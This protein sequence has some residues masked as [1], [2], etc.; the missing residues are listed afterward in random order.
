MLP[1]NKTNSSR[2]FCINPEK[3][4]A[5]ANVGGKSGKYKAVSPSAWL[6]REEEFLLPALVL[7]AA[8]AYFT[9][10]LLLF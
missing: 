6:C 8:G 2:I 1:H 7:S 3:E 10:V 9:D 4:R 5:R